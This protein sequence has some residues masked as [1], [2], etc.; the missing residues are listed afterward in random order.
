MSSEI[1]P[2]HQAP[3]LRRSARYIDGARKDENCGDETAHELAV[4]RNRARTAARTSGLGV[5]VMRALL[6]TRPL[7]YPGSL[8]KHVDMYS[9]WA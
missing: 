8:C 4:P 5:R 1:K 3:F 9:H 2:M 6:C 7:A